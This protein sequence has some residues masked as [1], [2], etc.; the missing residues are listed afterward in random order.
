MACLLFSGG[1]GGNSGSDALLLLGGLVG[2]I[3]GM[4]LL[5]PACVTVLTAG[6]G[7]RVPVAVRIALRDLVRQRARSGA[8]V[9]A[10]SFAV[11]LA[12]I[13]GIIA[14][15]RF[16]NVLDYAGQNLTS[17]QLIMYT[18]DQG[19]NAGPGGGQPAGRR[20]RDRRPG[21]DAGA[22]ERI[23]A[24]IA[25]G[26]FVVPI[27]AT[28][29]IEQTRAAVELQRAGHVHGKVVITLT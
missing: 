4:F 5:A 27:A 23:T 8:A 28:F 12:M 22:L 1:W 18:Q 26:E 15:V 29:P 16:S 10:V 14:S 19:P 7:P 17:D 24:A 20:A 9:A 6:A 13:I 2:L 25:A 3:A 21:R 11:F